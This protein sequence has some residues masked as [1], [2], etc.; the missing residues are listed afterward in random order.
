MKG[1][2]GQTLA[3]FNLRQNA[4][5]P[6]ATKLVVAYYLILLHAIIAILPNISEFICRTDCSI[7]LQ[8]RVV[9]VFQLN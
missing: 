8:I 9:F 3:P 1:L 7:Y 2:K 5:S 6:H 4:V